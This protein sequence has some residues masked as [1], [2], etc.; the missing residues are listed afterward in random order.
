MSRRR[1]RRLPSAFKTALVLAAALF[2]LA[3]VLLALTPVAAA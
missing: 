3:T 1:G 2:A